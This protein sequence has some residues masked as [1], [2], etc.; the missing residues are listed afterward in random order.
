MPHRLTLETSD[1][2]LH[3]EVVRLRSVIE[4]SGWLAAV[5]LTTMGIGL[6]VDAGGWVVE[7]LGVVTAGSAGVAIVGLVR[8]RRFET[9]VNRRFVSGRA[10]P[11]VGR[12][13]LGMVV[14]TA[15]RA[16]TS[17]RRL[18][19]DREVVLHGPG[20]DQTL[21]LP[22]RDPEA[23]IDAIRTASDGAT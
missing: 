14:E 17:W 22:S 6:A 1:I 11:L 4:A 3:F 23:L 2:P 18:Y 20:G 16:A 8:C 15:A 5:I 9:V 13:P 10:G 12:L 21:T 19:C 7:S